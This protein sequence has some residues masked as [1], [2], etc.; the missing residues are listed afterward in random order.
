MLTLA[1]NQELIQ[2]LRVGDSRAEFAFWERYSPALQR[3]ARQHLAPHLQARLGAEDV[4][5]AACWSFLQRVRDGEFQLDDCCDLWK[6][7][8]AITITKVREQARYHRRHRR[9]ID[10]E[11]RLAPASDDSGAYRL[12]PADL[13]DAPDDALAF[14]EQVEQLLAILEDDER[15]IVVLKLDNLTNDEVALRLNLSERTVR[16]KLKHVQVRLTRLQQ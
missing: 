3:L 11:I 2:G 8:A 16:R 5:Q 9:S 15:S 13:S 10:Q 1:D 14:S 12:D 6:M 7:L 4:V